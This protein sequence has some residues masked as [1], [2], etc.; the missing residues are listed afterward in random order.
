MKR[1]ARKWAQLV[2]SLPD[3]T[4]ILRGSLLQRMIRHRQGCSKCARG[5]GHPVAVLAVS[6][7]GGQI[8]Q[9]SL[10]REQ[11]PAVRRQ[12]ENYQRVK[13]SLE[14]ICELNQQALRTKVADSKSRR[15][16]RD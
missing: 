5:G 7:P 3:L 12:L 1:N 10:H 6:Y 9:I 14:E 4:D 13:A 2:R 16:N 15:G 8:R 11:V